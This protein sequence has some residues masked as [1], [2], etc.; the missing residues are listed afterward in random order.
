MVGFVVTVADDPTTLSSSFV[1]F[2]VGTMIFTALLHPREAYCLISGIVYLFALPSVFIFLMVYSVANIDNVSWGTREGKTQNAQQDKVNN[3]RKI[4]AKLKF[5]KKE[6]PVENETAIVGDTSTDSLENEKVDQEKKARKLSIG[7]ASSSPILSDVNDN[8]DGAFHDVDFEQE[9]E[10][11]KQRMKKQETVREFKMIEKS[12]YTFWELLI[13]K[14]LE[15]EKPTPTNLAKKAQILEMLR[16]LRDSSLFSLI[17]INT[18]IVFV[19]LAVYGQASLIILDSS[20]VTLILSIF[21]VL[22][23][24][25]FLGMIWHRFSM[26]MHVVATHN[27]YEQ[28]AKRKIRREKRLKKEGKKITKREEQQNAMQQN[29]ENE[30]QLSENQLSQNNDFVNQ[31]AQQ[32]GSEQADTLPSM[33]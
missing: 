32:P 19:F 11:L 17:L 6:K 31:F 33:A 4:L 26:V 2:L 20:A 1:L 14:Y 29:Q 18:I 5:W 28:D 7:R 9:R 23:L 22:V 10:D 24:L 25:Q 15:V 21:A 8:D 30:E 27:K 3:A 16:E 13:A 12:E